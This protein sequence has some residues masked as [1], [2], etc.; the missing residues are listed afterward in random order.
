MPQQVRLAH[1][2]WC[3]REELR[4]R[5]STSE[6]RRHLKEYDECLDIVESCTGPLN[7]MTKLHKLVEEPEVC[8]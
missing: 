3:D 2:G 7:I 5:V 8:E 6:G 1:D 4:L